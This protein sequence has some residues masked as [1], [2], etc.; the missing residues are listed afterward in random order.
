[1]TSGMMRRP[2]FLDY[3]PE[4]AYLL[5][6]L[7]LLEMSV[8]GH[9]DHPGTP[10]Q[11]FGALV[12]LVQWLAGGAGPAGLAESVLRDPERFL[13]GINIALNLLVGACAWFAARTLWRQSGRL[14]I[15]LLVPVSLPFLQQTAI[16]LGRV[17]P[18]PMLVA[19][20]LLVFALALSASADVALQG[21]WR[22][23]PTATRLFGAALGVGIA[24][25]VTFAPL[26][27]T[28]WLLPRGNRRVGSVWCAIAFLASIIPVLPFAPRMA[29]W[30]AS[31]MLNRGHLA[32]GD[33]GIPDQSQLANNL[34]GFLAGEPALFIAL[35]LLAAC[36]FAARRVPAWRIGGASAATWSAVA[37]TVGLL[38]LAI[39]L[40]HG[41]PRY[42]VAA[43]VFDTLAL[44]ALAGTL[45]S[46]YLRRTPLK[47]ALVS[48]AAVAAVGAAAASIATY[49]EWHTAY[50]AA[51]DARSRMLASAGD[52]TGCL[53]VH[54]SGSG[55]PEH[56][57]AF[58]ND[59]ARRKFAMRLGRLYSD[60][61]FYDIWQREFHGYDRADRL[62]MVVSRMASGGCVLMHGMPLSG[63]HAEY[64]RGMDLENLATDGPVTLYRLRGFI[65]QPTIAP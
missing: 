4:Y 41:A 64:A 54:Y 40:K 1:M 37:L 62:N 61:T 59:Y 30:F 12:L 31:L 63:T 29:G 33:V 45:P 25:K 19:A 58:G 28:I 46:S 47:T 20:T 32:S 38:Q 53:L 50:R 7:N 35:P 9:F 49:R 21:G 34:T 51:A 8:P 43:T 24:T 48:V 3:D 56:A 22:Q 60:A 52:H 26:L 13:A 14:G 65:R 5:N 55:S 44:L 57:M 23:A 6:S 42:V 27:A 17:T 36:C 2:Y 39:S 18:E 15:A 11:E 10:L 16:A